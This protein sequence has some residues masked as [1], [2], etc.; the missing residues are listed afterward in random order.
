MVCLVAIWALPPFSN[1]SG[2]L[3]W[4]NWVLLDGQPYTRTD[5]QRNT[6]S[7][8]VGLDTIE[9]YGGILA[10]RGEFMRMRGIATS[11]D[12]TMNSRKH[13][14]SRLKKSGNTSR[15]TASHSTKRCKLPLGIMHL[16]MQEGSISPLTSHQSGVKQFGEHLNLWRA[17]CNLLSELSV[18]VARQG[19]LRPS[20]FGDC[21]TQDNVGAPIDNGCGCGYDN[22]ANE[23]FIDQ[24]RKSKLLPRNFSGMGSYIQVQR[25]KGIA[26]E[27]L[28]KDD[29]VRAIIDFHYRENLGD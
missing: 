26:P 29:I 4:V 21:I 2:D 12:E 27:S 1:T 22:Y 5:A 10:N 6:I 18:F 11:G 25:K 20:L 23:Q 19:L 3:D 8:D 16:L 24:Q 15:T 28:L 7:A 13:Y 17:S 14:S 9:W